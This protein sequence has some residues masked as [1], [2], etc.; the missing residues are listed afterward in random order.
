MAA[1]DDYDRGADTRRGREVGM[2]T[3]NSLLGGTRHEREKDTPRSHQDDFRRCSYTFNLV[4][5]GA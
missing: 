1:L 4:P 3:G 5:R 2:L